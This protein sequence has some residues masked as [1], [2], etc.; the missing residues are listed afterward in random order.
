LAERVGLNGRVIGVDI[1]RVSLDLARRRAL[2]GFSQVSFLEADAQS[3]NLP[4]QSA[5]GIFSR[6]GVMAFTDPLAA[7]SNFHRI[8][9]PSGKLAF[10]CWRALQDNELDLLPLRTAGLE[11][12]A[13]PVP[14][15]TAPAG[16]DGQT[17]GHKTRSPRSY[18]SFLHGFPDRRGAACESASV[19]T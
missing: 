6:F 17:N 1:A 15:T 18:S 16:R 10:V 5:D 3:L 2:I 12:M 4:D 14:T 8:L 13:D 11:A 9:K 7:F 19:K